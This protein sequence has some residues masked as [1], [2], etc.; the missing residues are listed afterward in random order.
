M[1]MQ[2][3]REVEMT[4]INVEELTVEAGRSSVDNHEDC[5]LECSGDGE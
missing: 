4:V 5:I 3:T 1:E 2:Q